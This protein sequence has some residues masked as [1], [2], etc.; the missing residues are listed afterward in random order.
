MQ[1]E[2]PD[3]NDPRDIHI[4][5]LECEREVEGPP[6]E[7]EVISASIKV[8]KINI[9]TMENSKMASIGDY[10][11]EKIVESITEVLRDEGDS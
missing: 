11:D 8:K 9:G 1:E 5:E 3:E 4:E 7:S 10:W 6:V 2:A